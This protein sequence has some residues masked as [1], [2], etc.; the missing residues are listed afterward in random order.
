MKKLLT[1]IVFTIIGW[2]ATAQQDALYSSYRFNPLA[3]NPGYAG[4]RDAISVVLLHRSQWVGIDGAPMTQS[5]AIHS[6]IGNTNLA[7]GFNAAHDQ[8]GP[9]NNLMGFLTLAYHL[10]LKKGKLSFGLKGGVYDGI[11][12]FNQL[13]FNQAD[14]YE[15]SGTVHSVVPSFDFGVYYYTDYFFAGAAVS[16]MTKHQFKYENVPTNNEQYLDRH[17]NLMVGGAIPVHPNVVLKPSLKAQYVYGAPFTFDVNFSTL[18]YKKVWVGVSYR[19]HNSVVFLTEWNI[20]DFMRVGYAFDLAFNDLIHYNRGTHEIFLG[21]DFN[22][23]T[24]KI[25]SPRYL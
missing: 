14:P 10:P 25:I 16:H 2:Q 6:P 19:F 22:L 20:T 12:H 21:F 13:N 23:K 17:Y 4:S 9:T 24:K 3:L 5:L 1:L 11:F 8:I 18:L 15:S 7:I